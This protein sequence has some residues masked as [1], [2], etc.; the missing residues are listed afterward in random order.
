MNAIDVTIA[1][2]NV[3]TL[4]D[5]VFVLVIRNIPIASHSRQRNTVIPLPITTF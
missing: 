5:I 3:S 2:M 1:S 4:L